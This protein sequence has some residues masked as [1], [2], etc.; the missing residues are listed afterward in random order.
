MTLLQSVV[1]AAALSGGLALCA[2]F[3][4]RRADLKEAEAEYRF[5]PEGQ[6]VEVAGRRVHYVQKGSGPDLVLVHGA[7]GSTRDF[8]FSFLDRVTDRYRVTIF[9]RPGHGWSEH[10][11]DRYLRGFYSRSDT[12]NEQADHLAAATAALG[13]T[14]P[15]IVG[16]SY[17]G[18]VVLAWALRH[19]VAG[20]VT[21]SGVSHPWPGGNVSPLYRVNGSA[22]GGALAVPLIA[23]FPPKGRVEP[24]LTRIFTPDPVP[25]GY[26]DY[27]DVPMAMRR[28]AL[29]TNARQINT[30]YD[31]VAEQSKLYDTLQT[32]LEILHGTDD[33]IVPAE[34]HSV[35]LSEKVDGANL[36]LLPGTG[37]MP[38][39]TAPRA[40]EDAID[41]AAARAGLR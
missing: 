18:A 34:F 25:A 29:R 27:Y 6:F 24:I 30:V 2:V 5:P 20:V 13:I 11:D 36:T 19:Q 12:L 9:D 1:S 37:H 35:P 31:Q 22:L 39:H 4:D 14:N 38:H 3:V 7:G 41:R 26:R 15:L 16:Q 28:A 8:T 10:T 21:I 32:P 40:V 33:A 17:G 23:A